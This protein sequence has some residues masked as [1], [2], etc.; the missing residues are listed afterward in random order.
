MGLLDELKKYVMDA[1]PG[2]LL[3]P[4]WTP[5]RTK[6]AGMAMLDVT[7]VVGDVKSAV[8]GYGALKQGDYLGAGLGALG[9][10]P[11]VPNMAGMFIGKGAKTWDAVKASQAIDM[12]KAGVDPRKIWTETGNWRGPDGKWRQEIPDNK[13]SI[14]AQKGEAL[15]YLSDSGVA[16]YPSKLKDVIRHKEVFSS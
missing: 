6:A 12:E 13:S 4:E 7:P 11:L 10:L 1:M 3:N 5:E 2:G 15:E 14:K 16:A 9:A 8:D